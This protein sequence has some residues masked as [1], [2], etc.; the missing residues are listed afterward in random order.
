MVKIVKATASSIPKTDMLIGDVKISL[1]KKGK[2]QTG[3]PS[4]GEAYATFRAA[5]ELVGENSK[6]DFYDLLRMIKKQWKTNRK[7]AFPRKRYFSLRFPLV[8]KG[9][10]WSTLWSIFLSPLSTQRCF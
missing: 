3:S 2:S 1:K 6:S 5:G 8:F 10:L 9:S 4:K 7:S